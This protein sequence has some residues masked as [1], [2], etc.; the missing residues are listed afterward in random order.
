MENGLFR[1]KYSFSSKVLPR[2]LL[3]FL[4]NFKSDVASKRLTYKTCADSNLN[5][6]QSN[7]LAN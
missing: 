2:I 1:N 3:S 7:F 4:E 5:A 6:D